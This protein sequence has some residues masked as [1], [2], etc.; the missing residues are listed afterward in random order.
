MFGVLS[1]KGFGHGPPSVW[2]FGLSSDFER[3][4]KGFEGLG[5]RAFGVLVLRRILSVQGFALLL[6]SVWGFGP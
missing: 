1:D 4:C 3:Y 6:P 2:A 5:L